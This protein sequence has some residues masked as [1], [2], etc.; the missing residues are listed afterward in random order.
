MTTSRQVY[1]V[2]TGTANLASVLTALERCGA[3][4]T[5]TQRPE[6]I[7]DAPYVVLPGVGAFGAAMRRLT[8]SGLKEPLKQ[9]IDSGKPTL[10]ICL[11]MQ[12]LAEYSEESPNVEGL[13]IIRKTV[14]M[15]GAGQRIP[16]FGWNLVEADSNSRF[17]KTGYA[18][19]ANSFMLDKVDDDWTA[20]M[21]NYGGPFVAGM[22]RGNILACQFHPELSGKWGHELIERWLD[23]GGNKC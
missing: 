8:F 18:Y 12:L 15:F 2:S 22:E 20:A 3:S 17:F 5:V 21:S 13:G 19:F 6:D 1:I 16:Q 11:G 9:R 14:R 4:C 7:I 10:A 23:Q